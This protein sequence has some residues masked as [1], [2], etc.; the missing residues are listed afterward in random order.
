MAILN[1]NYLSKDLFTDPENIKSIEKIYKTSG[2]AR[3]PYTP[4]WSA[5]PD[6][7]EL[8][9]NHV[10]ETKPQNILECSS[11]TS[12]LVLAKCCELNQQGFVTSLEHEDEFAKQSRSYLS[13]YN[14]DNYAEVVHAP[15]TPV[16]T[17]RG[18]YLWY[19]PEKI[20]DQ[21]IDMLVI[22]GPPGYLQK[23]SRYPA[24]VKLYNKLSNSCTIFMDDA[25]RPD[26]KDIIALWLDKY[27]DISHEY[28]EL[29]R[30]CSILNINKQ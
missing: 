6:F 1:N 20:P 23:N 18:E 14:L 12:S 15:L 29:E 28:L 2:L 8:I 19:N 10:L 17:E 26:E 3:I 22:D 9:L 5:C 24:L 7:L 25:R 21:S 30:G 4:D 13:H 27:P 16:N 11:G